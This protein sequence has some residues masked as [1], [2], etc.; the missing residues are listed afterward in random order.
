MERTSRGK[1][2]GVDADWEETRLRNYASSEIRLV[3]IQEKLCSEVLRGQ[4]QVRWFK[5]YR[6]D[7]S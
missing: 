3:E 4:D 6:L 7:I 2:E 5:D 1:F